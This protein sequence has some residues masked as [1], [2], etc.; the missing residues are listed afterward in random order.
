M[1]VCTWAWGNTAVMASGKPFR[2]STTAMRISS[3]P[4][5]LSSVITRSQNL[6]PS[7]VRRRMI[8]SMEW[9]RSADCG[10]RLLDPQAQDLLAAIGLWPIP[11]EGCRRSR[12]RHERPARCTPPYCG[13][14]LHRGPSRAA[15]RRAPADRPPRGRSSSL[16]G[17]RPRSLLTCHSAISSRTASVT[18]LIRSGETRCHR[19]RP[20]GPGSRGRSCPGHT[21]TR[22][23]RPPGP[24]EAGPRIGFPRK[25]ATVL[26]DQLWTKVDS[27]SRGT[28]SAVFPSR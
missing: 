2:P 19:A 13:R 23:C 12:Q 15:R 26:G 16:R 1:Q 17:L 6:A 11:P 27:R 9:A 22:P 24:A 14:C 3:T 20:D 7:S 10:V 28:R 5:F 8:Q 4:R 21:S 25:P 18:A